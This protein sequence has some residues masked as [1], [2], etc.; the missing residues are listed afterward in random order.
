MPGKMTGNMDAYPNPKKQPEISLKLI[1]IGIQFPNAKTLEHVGTPQKYHTIPETAFQK[2]CCQF[3]RC[4]VFV[5]FGT[6]LARSSQAS[7]A[8]GTRT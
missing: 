8:G 6:T 1:T 2:L 7:Q 4:Q 3:G 5:L